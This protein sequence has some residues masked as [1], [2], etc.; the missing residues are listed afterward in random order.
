MSNRQLFEV[1]GAVNGEVENAN[2]SVNT[3]RRE[4]SKQNSL[5]AERVVNDALSRPSAYFTLHWDA[6]CF[7]AL[8]HCGEKQE[9]VAV[10]LRSS[11]GEEILLGMSK[12]RMDV[13]MKSTNKSFHVF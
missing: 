3:V 6:K 2:V 1:I 12:Y 8:T 5:L 13:L 4:R 7:K 11:T 9:R 10:I